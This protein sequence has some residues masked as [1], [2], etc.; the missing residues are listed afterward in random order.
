MVPSARTIRAEW[1]WKSR[2]IECTYSPVRCAAHGVN[3][4]RWT[5]SAR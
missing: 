2:F 3:R 4:A 1:E 5:R